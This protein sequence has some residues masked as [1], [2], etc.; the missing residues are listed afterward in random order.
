MIVAK[1]AGKRLDEVEDLTLGACEFKFRARSEKASSD[2]GKRADLQAAGYC[3]VADAFGGAS[4]TK[5]FKRAF[6]THG[7][8]ACRFGAHGDELPA[9]GAEVVSHVCGWWVEKGGVSPAWL[10]QASSVGTVRWTARP[11]SLRAAVEARLWPALMAPR[12]SSV[13]CNWSG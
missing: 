2:R 1:A 13:A 6:V 10:H 12:E 9:R 4:P 7:A 3:G 8:R 5:G 11:V